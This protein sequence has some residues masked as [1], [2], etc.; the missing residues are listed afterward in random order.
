MAARPPFYSKALWIVN[1]HNVLNV[2][3]TNGNPIPCRMTVRVTSAVGEMNKA[4]FTCVVNVAES[5]EEMRQFIE[6]QE[7]PK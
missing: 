5:E 3:D 7:K 6:Q 1:K 4:I 2:Y